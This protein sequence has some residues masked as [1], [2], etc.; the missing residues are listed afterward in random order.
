MDNIRDTI[1]KDASDRFELMADEFRRDLA[2][3]TRNHMAQ[4]SEK[5]RLDWVDRY[6]KK[7]LKFLDKTVDVLTLVYVDDV[8]QKT[9]CDIATNQFATTIKTLTNEIKELGIPLI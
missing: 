2:D 4:D 8:D 5:E 1:A 3:W 7:L 9:I 6:M